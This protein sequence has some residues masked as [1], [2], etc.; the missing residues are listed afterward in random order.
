MIVRALC[1]GL[2]AIVVSRAVDAQE[3]QRCSFETTGQ[4]NIKLPSGNYNTFLGGN[5]VLRCPAK[6][7]TITADSLESYGDEG[8]TFL[9]GHVHYNEPRLALTS[10][11]LTYYQRDERVIAN[12]NV[13]AR[14]PSGSTLKGPIAEYLRVIPNTRPR[15]KLTATGR[16]TISLV[17]K[18][19]AGKPTE[20]TIVVANQVAMD[21]DSLVYA[22]GAV[23]VTRTD[24]IARGDSMALDSG[25][26]IT[27]M[28]RSPSIEGRRERPFTLVGERIELTSRN[29]KLER[30]IA[31]GKG[32]AVSEDMTLSSDTI[33]LRVAD[34]LLQRAIAWGPGPVRARAKSP[35][36]EIV[37]DSIDVTMP[38]QKIRE[39][40]AVRDAAAE[41]KPDS[42]R[43]KA[44]TTDWMR[45]D[46]I[47]A[48][49]DTVPAKDTSK[50]TKIRELVALGDAKSF[51]HLAPSDSAERRAAFNYVVGREI[52]VSF[53][54]Q[55]VS[56]V[57]VIDQAAGV[58]GEP[59]R[60][61]ARA[62]SDTSAAA[63]RAA[64]VTTPATTPAR[65]PLVP[66]TTTPGAQPQPKKPPTSK[67]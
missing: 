25:R 44:D 51:Y 14:L 11:F 10:D 57:T 17:Q 18:D 49:F 6:S 66:P 31:K 23:T 48:R 24:V 59:K 42:V 28:M 64:P 4:L 56:K 40:H 34:D 35:T 60:V 15:S 55:K 9:L 32:K 13:D 8:R 61:Q 1:V 22:G 38:N 46:T 7:V 26:E 5:V 62:T 20:P 67:P 63:R 27:V 2:A 58:Y 47:V 54:D 39:M 65:P 33:D 37:S 16:P 3:T 53:Q 52:I 41:G 21:G 50:A 36:Q 30:V 12:G 45:G 19:S 29:R 43:F